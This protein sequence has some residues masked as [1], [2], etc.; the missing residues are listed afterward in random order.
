MD[1]LSHSLAGAVV[2]ELIHR[3][4]PKE[5]D[6]TG[7][8][9]RQR[10]ILTTSVLASS[11]PDLDLILTPLLPPPLGY[12]LHHRGHTHTVLYSIPQALLLFA[13]IWICWPSARQLLKSSSVAKKG[14]AL[15]LT[16]G[17][18]LHLAMDYLNSYGIH[19]FHPFN[20]NW[21]YGDM[22]FIVE[23]FFWVAFGT[24]LIMM[25]SRKAIR[26]P[27]LFLLI[28]I[29]LFF[30]INHFLAWP[31]FALLMGVATLLIFARR[32]ALI[33]SLV[34]GLLFVTAQ[35]F[36]SYRANKELVR[37]LSSKDPQ[38][39]FVDSP[40]TPF[41]TNPLCW[42]FV[43]IESN[44]VKKVYR[45]RRGVLSLA[46]ETFPASHCP[47]RFFEGESPLEV[48]SSLLFFYDKTEDLE[49]LR[50]LKNENCYFAA[51]LRFARAPSIQGDQVSDLR[52]SRSG[53]NRNFTT[54]AL[55]QFK[56]MDCP[57]YV[58]QW[59]FPRADLLISN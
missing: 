29:P 14:F 17:F 3:S 38:S 2:G 48:T 15:A 41:P 53:Q 45:L 58:P 31:S 52:F 11:F 18:G 4:L 54:M 22:V 44:E 13:L 7:N 16:L 20:S 43:T 35:S 10:L 5:A 25:I 1:N 26:W 37:V 50:R 36:S 51:W 28:G 30:T 6:S 27:L 33:L 47:S 19:P 42:M 55:D 57:A 12:L 46:P 34:S 24:P 9:V 49:G 21:F 32:R 40:L 59:G 8:R 39:R 56:G 23:P